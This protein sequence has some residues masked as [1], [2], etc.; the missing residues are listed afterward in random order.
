MVTTPLAERH[1]NYHAPVT[2]E[3]RE[4]WRRDEQGT[5]SQ[6]VRLPLRHMVPSPGVPIIIHCWRAVLIARQVFA[7]GAICREPSL[8]LAASAPRDFPEGCRRRAADRHADLSRLSRTPRSFQ[9]M[10]RARPLRTE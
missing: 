3:S 2:S 1:S 7:V 9:E 8:R 10:R 6:L 4:T 5:F